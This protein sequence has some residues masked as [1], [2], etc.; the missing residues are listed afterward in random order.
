MGSRDHG[1]DLHPPKVTIIDTTSVTEYADPVAFGGSWN[2]VL[3]QGVGVVARE[4][5]TPP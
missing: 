5:N 4:P 2:T 3:G 1:Y